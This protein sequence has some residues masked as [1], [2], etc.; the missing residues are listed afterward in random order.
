MRAYLNKKDA[1]PTLS[2]ES[3]CITGQMD[4]WGNANT[5]QRLRKINM[6]KESGI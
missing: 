5:L 1:D 6:A 2:L 3:S 4:G